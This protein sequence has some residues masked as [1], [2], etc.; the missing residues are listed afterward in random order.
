MHIEQKQTLHLGHMEATAALLPQQ[1]FRRCEWTPIVHMVF[2]SPPRYRSSNN[3][4]GTGTEG[5]GLL[6]VEGRKV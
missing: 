1:S 6:K 5:G 2:T 4:Y 3:T